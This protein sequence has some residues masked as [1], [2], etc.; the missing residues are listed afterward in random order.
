MIE[1]RKE[2]KII[3]VGTRRGSWN[4]GCRGEIRLYENGVEPKGRGY[5][6]R[7]IKIF[8]DYNIDSTGPRS[9]V[10]RKINQLKEIYNIIEVTL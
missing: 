8:G 1:K 9:D 4:W 2:Y 7:C 5:A 3:L 6:D 10:R